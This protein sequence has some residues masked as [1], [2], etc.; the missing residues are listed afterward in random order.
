[1]K[2]PFAKSA[3]SSGFRPGFTLIELLVVISIIG[4]LA[5]LLLP[6]L[7]KAKEQA[8]RARCI[9]N[10]K[11]ITLA[12]I[13]YVGDNEDIL[14]Y[15]GW[16][17]GTTDKPNWIY[18]RHN[19]AAGSKLRWDDRIEEG[20]LWRYHTSPGLLWCP[21]HKTNSP[22]WRASEYQVG[23]YVMNGAASG[24]GTTSAGVAF[25]SFKSTQFKPDAV[26]FWE[27]DESNPADWD[28][29]TSNPDEGI[30]ARHNNGSVVSTLG[31]QAEYFST[32]DF[33]KE[34]GSNKIRGYPGMKPGR[35]WCAPDTRD[36]T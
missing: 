19:R 20:Q 16:S 30:T 18:T 32:I 22:A 13:M 3:F 2:T 12:M 23:S 15:T 9:S 10:Q 28:N 26:M 34:S 33:I 17:S 1:M 8:Q 27:A 6:A 36:G 25:R 7:G 29:A 31:G 4:I 14:P 24:Y 11:Q 5:S 21:L 35:L